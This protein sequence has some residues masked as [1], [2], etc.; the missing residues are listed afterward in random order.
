LFFDRP[1]NLVQQWRG[2]GPGMPLKWMIRFAL[3]IR[4]SN[5]NLKSVGKLGMTKNRNETI[6]GRVS[7][8]RLELT[9]W[10]NYSLASNR[11]SRQVKPASQN[12]ENI[13]N[14]DSMKLVM[15]FLR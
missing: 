13:R 12:A 10:P 8:N 5:S 9:T 3:Q 1:L 15:M 2:R 14:R 6:G 7:V 4:V 11:S